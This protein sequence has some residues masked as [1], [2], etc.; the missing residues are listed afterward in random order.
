MK[1]HWTHRLALLALLL[2]S[3]V[4]AQQG[5]IVPDAL[6]AAPA[7]ASDEGW[8]PKLSL[9]A[10][11]SYVNNSAVV[12][13]DEGTTVQVGLVLDGS[14][15]LKSGQ[16]EWQ[17][18]LKVEH[19]QTRTPLLER[20]VK[21]ADS[22]EF[23][24]LYLY[25]LQ[26]MP[27]LGPY[28]RLKVNTALFSGYLVKP[29][30]TV[31]RR[32]DGDGKVTDTTVAAQEEFSVTDPFEPLVLTESAG[33]FAEPVKGDLL[34]FTAK[35][36]A[37]G[38]HIFAAGGYAVTDDDTTPELEMTEILTSHSAGGELELELKGALASNLTWGAVANFFYPFLTTSDVDLSGLDLL[39]SDLGANLSVKLAQWL[40]LDYVLKAKKLPF[41]VQEWQVQNSLLLT[42]GFNLL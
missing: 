28:A 5:E 23:K 38:Q 24:S 27:W 41:V 13:Q 26:S 21:S 11:G 37:G 6:P 4:A 10:T 42:A 31:V 1:L 32:T 39:H 36:G 14:A 16:S 15:V 18:G 3:S 8:T 29:D 22:L 9:G 34:T 12:G 20:F 17:N 35:L 40:S 19:S 33:A 30:A 25:R 2:P 7:A